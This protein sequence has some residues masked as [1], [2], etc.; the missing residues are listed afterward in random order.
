M[1]RAIFFII[2]SIL[3]LI[4]SC[5]KKEIKSFEIAPVFSD[6]MVL[7]RNMEVKVW[8]WGS[9]GDKVVVEI[10]GQSYETVVNK[11]GEWSVNLNRMKEGGPFVLKAFCGKDTI[12]VKN[13]M[14]GEVW[15]CSG[16]SNMEMPLIGFPPKDTI[17][18]A[19]EEIKNADYPE[20]RLLTV[21]RHVSFAHE[22]KFSGQW[23]VCNP[24]N[25][26]NFSATAYFF[27]RELYEN[28]GVPIGL[29]S[30]SWGGTPIEAWTG[31]NCLSSVEGFEDIVDRIEKGSNEYFVLK[32]WWEKLKKINVPSDDTFWAN[33]DLNYE[34][35]IDEKTEGWYEIDLPTLWESSDLGEFD[36][37]VWF[38][39]I[40]NLPS[41]WMGKKLV[42]ELGPIDDMDRTFFNG[43]EIGRIEK[44]GYWQEKRRYEIPADIVR[45]NN[46]I[47]VR[48]IDTRGGG[49]IYG[50]KED[51]KI[52]P[53]DNPNDYISI[54]GAWYYKP[55]AEFVNN[56]LYVFGKGDK[57]FESRPKLTLNLTPYTPST[58]F[59]GMIYPLVRFPIRGVIWYQ[60][61][62]NVGNASKY[63]SLF[64]TMINCWRKFWGYDFPFYFVQIA[65]YNYGGGSQ[66]QLLREAQ[67]KTMLAV[68][69]TGMVVTTDIGDDENIHPANKQDV[70]KRLALWALAKTYG[71]MDIVCSG[72]IYERIEIEGDK[73]RVF[74]KYARNGLI[75]KPEDGK[76]YFQIAGENRV[77][78]PAEVKVEGNTLIVFSD[79]VKNPVAVRYGWCNTPHATIFNKEG[80]PASPFRTDSW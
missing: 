74:F 64:S 71:F 2:I 49:G 13:V 68:E 40:V 73:I 67:L 39:K 1:K 30:S 20:I 35:Y 3:L 34:L 21:N 69:N 72:P 51:M 61:E 12:S 46:V 57:S 53:L 44:M 25:V 43:F 24:E 78:Y 47:A 37:V 16:Q 48:V 63:F 28:L 22:Y 14:I 59:N 77:F 8:G 18:N 19:Q 52:Y 38:K 41:E 17:K 5:P 29:I 15:L 10:A 32:N 66:S 56:T 23:K 62:S 79:K 65:P 36:G 31:A 4:I 26:R 9:P 70:G 60:G 80:L 50:S 33:L 55:V 76:S 75:Y 7:Q 6:N 54:S 27:G 45:K 58:L 11:N 42:I